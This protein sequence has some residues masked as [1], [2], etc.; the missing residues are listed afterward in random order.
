MPKFKPWAHYSTEK[1][2]DIQK[3]YQLFLKSWHPINQKIKLNRKT[4]AAAT[5]AAGIRVIENKTAG[6]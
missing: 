2:C 4:C 1:R 6:I 3:K 5:G